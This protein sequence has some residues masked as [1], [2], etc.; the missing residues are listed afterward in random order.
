MTWRDAQPNLPPG[1]AWTTLGEVADADLGKMLDRKK[2]TGEHSM[3]YL[4][5]IN[6]RWHTLDLSDILTMDVAPHERDRYTVCAGD[7]LVCEGG[8]PGRAAIVPDAASGLAYQKALHRLR[9]ADGIDA[10]YLA[11]AFEA[12]ASQG[13]LSEHTTGSTIRHLPREQ[14]VGLWLPVAPEAEQRRIADELEAQMSRFDAMLA[15]V[16]QLVGPITLSKESRLGRLRA[17]LLRQAFAGGLVP[18][19]AGDEPAGIL[20]RRVAEARATRASGRRRLARTPRAPKRETT[21]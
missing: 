17:L 15:A 6:V 16:Q 11:Y 10:R 13:H 5:N 4:R 14:I 12:M 20:L 18:Q 1:W 9:P 19:D 7:L 3:K 2:Q 21:A 8:E